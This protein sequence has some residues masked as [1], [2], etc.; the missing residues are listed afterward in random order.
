MFSSYRCKIIPHLSKV[1]ISGEG[2]SMVNE[3]LSKLDVVSQLI[4]V[5]IDEI[6]SNI[7]VAWDVVREL[8]SSSCLSNDSERTP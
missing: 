8:P 3:V 6:R 7:V 4:D 1:G 5:D 2:D